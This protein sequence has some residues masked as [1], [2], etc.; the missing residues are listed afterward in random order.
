MPKPS[1]SRPQPPFAAGHDEHVG[2]AE[3]R[4]AVVVADVTQH[5]HVD[6]AVGGQPFEMAPLP[7]VTADRE[8][9][10]GIRRRQPVGRL[11][12][13]V[14]ALAR[15]ETAHAGQQR[16]GGGQPESRPGRPDG[17]AP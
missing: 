12:Q 4:G 2:G 13:H 16:G 5:P 1:C 6:E 3:E 17:R 9:E 10:L 8:N 11:D 15:H 14:H 7:P